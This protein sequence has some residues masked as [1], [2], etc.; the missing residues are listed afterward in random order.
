MAGVQQQRVDHA[1]LD[2]LEAGERMAGDDAGLLSHPDELRRQDQP[3]RHRRCGQGQQVGHS[4]AH[5]MPAR[6]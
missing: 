3:G 2:G 1:L 6:L 4:P 5:R